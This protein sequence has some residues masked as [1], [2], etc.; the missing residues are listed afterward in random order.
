M[1][2]G[3]IENGRKYNSLRDDYWGPSDDQQFET[4]DA[5]HLLYL[6]LNN[7]HS[8]ML[9]RAPV[10]KPSNVLDLGEPFYQ[11]NGPIPIFN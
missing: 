6:L 4:M 3:H 2:R 1:I 10:S 9:F 11:E 5:G 8:N 7:D